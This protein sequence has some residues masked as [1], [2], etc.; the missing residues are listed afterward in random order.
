MTEHERLVKSL[1]DE[2]A[3][4]QKQL[5]DAKRTE[6]SLWNAV[7]EKCRELRISSKNAKLLANFVSETI[8]QWSKEQGAKYTSSYRSM[9]SAPG[10][11]ECLNR[12][13]EAVESPDPELVFEPVPSVPPFQSPQE[14]KPV[15]VVPQHSDTELQDTGVEL[16]TV[17][18]TARTSSAPDEKF[19]PFSRRV[20]IPTPF[21]LTDT[22]S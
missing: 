18:A 2:I 8:Y 7:F 22:P 20:N 11:I 15:V 6:N 21:A 4:L 19:N 3:R 9:G 17:V 14:E 16:E 1:E 13:I 5:L 10:Y 12:I